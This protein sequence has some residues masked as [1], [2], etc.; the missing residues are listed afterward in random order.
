ME[1]LSTKT[2][3]W[4]GLLAVAIVVYVSYRIFTK[5]SPEEATLEA[6]IQQLP[7]DTTKVTVSTVDLN[8]LASQLYGAMKGVGTDE[9]AIFEVFNKIK[10]KD[11]LHALIR[12]FGIRDDEDL[13]LWLKGE[14]SSDDLLV[15]KSIFDDLG[16][17]F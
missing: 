6:S 4:L 11:D 5:K 10:S 15:I 2:K 1:K 7:V 13:R 12:T 8:T 16:V 17:V 3:I 9:D 14:L